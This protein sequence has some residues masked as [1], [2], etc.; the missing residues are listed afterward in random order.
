MK[1]TSVKDKNKYERIKSLKNKDRVIQALYYNGIPFEE[2]NENAPI[3]ETLIPKSSKKR[4]K[5]S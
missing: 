3:D 2:V 4:T 1:K 5:K